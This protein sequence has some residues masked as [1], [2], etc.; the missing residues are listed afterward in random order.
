MMA[1][2]WDHYKEI[3]DQVLI[4]ELICTLYAEELIRTRYA[5]ELIRRGADTKTRRR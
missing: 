4:F 5:E 3:T 1:D 2:F